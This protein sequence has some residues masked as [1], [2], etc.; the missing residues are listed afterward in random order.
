MIQIDVKQFLDLPDWKKIELKMTQSKFNSYP[1]QTEQQELHRRIG[2]FSI[3]AHFAMQDFNVFMNTISQT[4]LDGLW[5]MA[6]ELFITPRILDFISIDFFEKFG[7]C[8]YCEDFQ[9]YNKIDYRVR[10]KAKVRSIYG[11]CK[12]ASEITENRSLMRVLPEQRCVSWNPLRLIEQIID[13]KIKNLLEQKSSM[14]YYDDYKKDIKT[15]DL[16]DYFQN[17]YKSRG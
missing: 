4:T 7:I 10:K 13:Q 3:C 8:Y 12:Q 2:I 1:I 11:K 15:I 14:Y 16:W 6:M 17:R 9:G 5:P